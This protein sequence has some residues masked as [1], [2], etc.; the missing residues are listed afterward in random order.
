MV[1]CH[2]LG[3]FWDSISWENACLSLTS[4]Q[5]TG[6]RLFDQN[7]EMGAIFLHSVC[8]IAKMR[9]FKN[10]F[11]GKM[12]FSMQFLGLHLLRA[13]LPIFDQYPG[14]WNALIRPKCGNGGHF[15][16]QDTRKWTFLW[17]KMAQKWSKMAKSFIFLS[18][19]LL[20]YA[21][22]TKRVLQSPDYCQNPRVI[23]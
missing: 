1:K 21:H 11:D 6:T 9:F 8:K 23:T 17:P 18:Y 20:Y 2:F 14:H 22:V 10:I 12:P 15:C 5:V 7:V 4:T 3:S 13:C 19:Y 16:W